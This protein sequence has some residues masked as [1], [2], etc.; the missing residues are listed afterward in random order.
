MLAWACSQMCLTESKAKSV[1]G[2]GFTSL[3]SRSSMGSLD[4]PD[5]SC[6]SLKAVLAEVDSAGG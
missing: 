3:L 5:E 4:G 6:M 2:T 1:S